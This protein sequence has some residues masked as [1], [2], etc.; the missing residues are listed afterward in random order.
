MAAGSLGVYIVDA[1]LIRPGAEQP[2]P[3]FM[4]LPHFQGQ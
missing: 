3:I 1:R 2:L 4:N